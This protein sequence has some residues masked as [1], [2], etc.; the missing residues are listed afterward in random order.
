VE[1]VRPEEVADEDRDAR[2]DAEASLTPRGPLR[3]GAAT[4]PSANDQ[5]VGLAEEL[6]RAWQAIPQYSPVNAESRLTSGFGW[7]RSPVDRRREFHGGIDLAAPRGTS[8]V[9]PA[10]AFV[11]RVFVDGRAGLVVVLEHG[12]GLQTLY[13]HLDRVLVE[14]GQEVGR[15][16]PIATVGSTG[17]RTTGPHLHYGIKLEGKYV[18]P[19]RYLFEPGPPVAVK[20]A[21]GRAS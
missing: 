12:N 14:P 4:D 6:R 13:G 9:A 3:P 17:S 19:R 20:K 2:A 8:V 11:E 1:N 15:G 21:K 10:D 7:R 16:V 18:N 5:L